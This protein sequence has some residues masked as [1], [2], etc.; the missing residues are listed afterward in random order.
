LVS[1]EPVALELVPSLTTRAELHLVRGTVLEIVA[2]NA[3][4]EVVASSCSVRD[5]SGADYSALHPLE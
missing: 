4:G 2:R 3:A 5:A 1:S